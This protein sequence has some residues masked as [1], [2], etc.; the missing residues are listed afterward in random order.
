[1]IFPKDDDGRHIGGS[2]MYAGRFI[3]DLVKFHSMTDEEK[4]NTVGRDYTKVT[5][6]KGY[7]NRPE[8][9][10]L[11]AEYYR[12]KGQQT[13]EVFETRFHT[14]RGHGSIYRQAMPYIQGS[15]QGLYFICF[16]RALSEIDNALKRMTGHFQSDGSTDGLF[17]FTRAVTSNYYYCPSLEE[18]QT[19]PTTPVLD[20]ILIEVD[21]KEPDENAVRIVAEYCTNCG[22]YT[23]YQKTKEIIQSVLPSVFFC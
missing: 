7:D 21:D 11:D 10:R 6:H 23:I 15:D 2:Y 22:Y 14:H 8:N 12:S 5:P 4:S 9:P 3:H 16:S 20:P 17:D 18:L 1:L 13:S 19:L